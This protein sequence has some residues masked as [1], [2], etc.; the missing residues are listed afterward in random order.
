MAAGYPMG[1][2]SDRAGCYESDYENVRLA[3]PE[4]P[5]ADAGNCSASVGSEGDCMM[6]DAPE[7]EGS[8][9]DYMMYNAPE[10]EGSEGDYMMYNA[11][12]Q[13]GSEGNCIMSDAPEEEKEDGI[14][15]N[16]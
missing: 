10:Q 9:G 16:Y 12:E 8:E 2:H 3:R 15:A 14:Y 1:S 13:E 4:E 6:C 11:P 7:E 5:K